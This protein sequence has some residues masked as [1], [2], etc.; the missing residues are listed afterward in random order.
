MHILHDFERLSFFFFVPLATE[1]V[2][3]ALEILFWPANGVRSTRSLVEIQNK[4]L[5]FGK[6][7]SSFLA[8]LKFEPGG[9]VKITVVYGG[10]HKSLAKIALFFPAI[11]TKLKRIIQPRSYCQKIFFS[12]IKIRA[13]LNFL[14]RCCLCKEIIFITWLQFICIS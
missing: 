3:L 13:L 1:K 11:K 6:L 12:R 8:V 10:Y 4:H 14:V 5:F 7:K 9:L 2:V